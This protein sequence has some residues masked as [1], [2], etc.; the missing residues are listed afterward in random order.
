MDA[1]RSP[2]GNIDRGNEYTRRVVCSVGSVSPFFYP[3][4]LCHRATLYPSRW[5]LWTD[6][7]ARKLHGYVS[8][9]WLGEVFILK[10]NRASF[11]VPSCSPR[12]QLRYR[13]PINIESYY[14]SWKTEI[15]GLLIRR[16]AMFCNLAGLFPPFFTSWRGKPPSFS[17]NIDGFPFLP[18][19]GYFPLV[20]CF[21][22][23]VRSDLLLFLLC[24]VR[25][26]IVNATAKLR[27][28]LR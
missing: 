19:A 17:L 23:T 12:V 28:L 6:Q 15:A 10:I 16:S 22:F 25:H 21:L 14:L 5:A 2:Q 3:R 27:I 13:L 20:L 11:A 1:G 8:S 18:F 26:N 4:R 24:N 9:T 7:D